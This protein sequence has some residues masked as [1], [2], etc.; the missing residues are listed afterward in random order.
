MFFPFGNGR[1]SICSCYMVIKYFT[2]ILFHGCA[3]AK[4]LQL[5][6]TLCDPMDCSPPGSSV[7]GILQARILERV[8]VPLSPPSELQ[9]IPVAI[10]EQSGV[11]CFHS[12]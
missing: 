2:T 5:C 11:L 12:R 8:A 6:Q 4:S 7:H 9:E 1:V 3:R 10:R